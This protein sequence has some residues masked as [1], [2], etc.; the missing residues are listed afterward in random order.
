MLAVESITL[1]GRSRA[2]LIEAAY[3][4]LFTFGPLDTLIDDDAV[5]EI[6]VDGPDTIAARRGLGRLER[7]AARFA[8]PAHLARMTERLLA[9]GE[10][11][12]LAR[13]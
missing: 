7:V 9:L 2:A 11:G 8:T 5:T 6:A 1:D 3:A 12:P 13:R 4:S 10:S